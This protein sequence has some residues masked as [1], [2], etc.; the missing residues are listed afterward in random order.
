L[1]DPI[2]IAV[3]DD[4]PEV[5]HVLKQGLEAEGF[6]VVEA[7]DKDA[8]L[9]CLETYPIKLITLDLKLDHQEGLTLAREI[10]ASR[11]VPIIMITGYDAPLDRVAGLEQGADD[12]ITK[13]F[14]IKEVVIRVRRVLTTYGV[15]DAMP[16]KA[17]T[18]SCYA[19]DGLL[20]DPRKQELRSASGSLIELTETEV[21]LLTLFLQ[22]PGRVFSRD[23]ITQMLRGHEW[24]PL[25][26]MIDGHVSRLRR[27]IDIPGKD[28]T[29]FIKSVRG[30]GY[31]FAGKVSHV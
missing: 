20:F 14:H 18:P 16:A 25:D 4:E 5:R 30:V 23:E 7:G 29:S 22:H 8:C 9:L 26:R 2:Y 13:P 3:V 31:A 12:Y 17:S 21:R 15:L 6:V 24:S 1:A 27:K 10:R 11:N 19:F 28:E